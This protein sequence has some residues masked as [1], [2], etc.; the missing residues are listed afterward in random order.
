MSYNRCILM[1]RL[2]AAPEMKSTGDGIEYCRFTVAC[3]RDYVK[4]GQEREADFISCTAWRGTAAFVG[5]YFSKGSMIH[6]EGKWRHEK[7]EKDGEVRYTDYC[8]VDNVS[9]CGSKSDSSEPKPA[10][11]PETKPAAN[12]DVIID[13]DDDLPF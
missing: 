4:K 8:M 1:G 5:K 7:Y 9:F 2:T 10:A 11:A 3:D 13:D 12:L 6:V